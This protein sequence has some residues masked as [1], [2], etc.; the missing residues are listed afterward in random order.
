MDMIAERVIAAREDGWQDATSRAGA[1]TARSASR[2]SAARRSTT[3]RTT[4]SR[5]SSPRMGAI[6]IEN[7]ARI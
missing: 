5:S 1:S 2:T 7:Q 3:R 4:S 6:Q